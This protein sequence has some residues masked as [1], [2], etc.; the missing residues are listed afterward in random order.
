MRKIKNALVL[1]GGDSTRFWPLK[2][3]VLFDFL[4]SP[5][6]LYQIRQ[7]QKY[8]DAVTVISARDNAT[9]I[10]RLIENL[11]NKE[12]VHII[13]QKEGLE[14]QAGAILTAK[15][16]L[17]GETIIL[18]ANDVFD[19]SFLEK[20]ARNPASG[21][22]II[23]TGKRQ[24][25]YFSGGYFRFDDNK[26]LVEIIEKPGPDA[27][28]SNVVRLV[29]DYFSDFSMIVKAIESVKTSSDDH[30]EKAI[31]FILAGSG[32]REYVMYEG[33]WS[34]LKY[35]WHVLAMLKTML[36]AVKKTDIHDSAVISKKALI[37]G[38]VVIGEN[39]RI[40]DFVKVVGPA[41]IGRNTVVGD[42]SLIR[43]SQIG[44]DCLIGSYT[45]VA[46]SHIGN[47]V[48]LHR[49]YVGDSVLSDDSMMGSGA[50]TANLRF[51][52]KTISSGSNDETVDTNMDKLGAVIGSKSK[53]GVNSTIVP[54]VKIGQNCIIAP[55][56]KV[57]FDLEDKTYLIR[58]EERI[59][60]NA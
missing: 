54:G 31:N 21:G 34:T 38:P 11:E 27:L 43:E 14:G 59:N 42:Y 23:L 39:A 22:K 55:A 13:V 28:P 1:A 2:G 5:L 24:N 52:G 46:R 47:R 15:N 17:Q 40:G 26:N 9:T 56:E 16:H 51:D 20:I 8:A 44:E 35:P 36:A 10:G 58:G 53:I 7:L 30:Y 49:N 3:K 50:V 29:V 6:I 48:F 19:Y 37:I 41:F 32:A 33:Y 45:E 12:N 57:R 4:G 25:E 60:Q 18:N